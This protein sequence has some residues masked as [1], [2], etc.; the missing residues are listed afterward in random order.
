MI[1]INSENRHIAFYLYNYSFTKMILS[2]GHSFTKMILSDGHQQIP[3]EIESTLIGKGAN[4]G[5]SHQICQ[6]EPM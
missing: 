3:S 4:H 1:N 6:K 2:G 5:G